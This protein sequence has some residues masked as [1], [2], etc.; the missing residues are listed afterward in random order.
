MM[1]LAVMQRQ[2]ELGLLAAYGMSERQE[3]HMLWTE[4]ML[5]TGLSSFTSVVVG[6]LVGAVVGA[7]MVTPGSVPLVLLVWLVVASVIVGLISAITPAIVAVR[8]G[9]RMLHSE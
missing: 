5:I 8:S 6:G 7:N 2:R 3:K 9:A 1:S 4:A